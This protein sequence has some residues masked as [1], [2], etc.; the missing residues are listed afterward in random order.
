METPVTAEEYLDLDNDVA[1][2][3]TLT[4]EDIVS[5]VRPVTCDQENDSSDDENVEEPVRQ[6]TGKQA[7]SGLETALLYM[8]QG[9]FNVEQMD[10]VRSLIS[11]V[12]SQKISES[13]QKKVTDFF[14]Q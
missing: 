6:V 14:R 12:N 4:D 11:C 3:A 13:R 5:L 2:E 10:S 8:E 1:T 9:G 7:I